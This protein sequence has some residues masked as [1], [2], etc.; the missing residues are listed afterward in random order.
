MLA[1]ESAHF[2]LCPFGNGFDSH[3]IWETLYSGSIPVVMN[4]HTFNCLDDL[5]VIMVDD[6]KN[7]TEQYLLNRLRDLRYQDLDFRKLE[8]DWWIDNI[9]KNKIE[10]TSENISINSNT[11]YQKLF[12]LK[13]SCKQKIHSLLKKLIYNLRRIKKLKK[14]VKK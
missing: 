7:I 14:Y 5:P 4:H 2:V 6:F 12:L 1:L 11:M 10:P 13:L 3:R 9:R 8:Q